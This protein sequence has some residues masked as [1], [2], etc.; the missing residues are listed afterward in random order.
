MRILLVH[1]NFPG[2]YKYLAPALASSPDNEVVAIGEETNIR[3]LQGFHPRV[4]LLGYPEPQGAS[5]QT[6]HYLHS[7]EAAIRRGQAVARLALPCAR[8]GFTPGRDLRTSW[9]G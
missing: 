5:K 1:Q 8:Q 6:H 2:Q 3:R 4:R 7:T 9:L